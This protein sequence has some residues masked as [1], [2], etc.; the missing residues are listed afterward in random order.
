[1]GKMRSLY[2]I[3]TCIPIA[4]Q[5]FGKHIPAGA[6]A[7]KRRT[8]TDRQR[9]TKHVSLI[10]ETAFSAWSVQSRYKEVFDSIEQ[11]RTVV[12]LRIELSSS[13]QLA[14]K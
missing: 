8:Y 10:T 9:I 6:K 1:M 12:E 3:V 4:R 11:Y 5:R 7:R 13:S 14:G 2:N